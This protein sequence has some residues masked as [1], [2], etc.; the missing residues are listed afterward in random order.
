MHLLNILNFKM[1]IPKFASASTSFHLELKKRIQEYF[2][3]TGKSMTGGSRLVFKG[4]FLFV[5][6]VAIYAHLIW[7]TPPVFWGIVECIFLG[8]VIAA[9]GFNVMHDGAHG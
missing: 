9:I 1:S 4:S 2:T 7:F 5:L 8:G 6:F 3:R